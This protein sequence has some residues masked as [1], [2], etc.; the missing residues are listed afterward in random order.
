M[1]AHSRISF[2]V[3]LICLLLP[4]EN[5]IAAESNGSGAAQTIGLG[6]PTTAS[7]WIMLE[8]SAKIR[9]KAQITSKDHHQ[10]LANKFNH[11]TLSINL[12]VKP[13]DTIT[14]LV[15][16]NPSGSKGIERKA[17]SCECCRPIRAV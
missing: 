16:T 6:K 17:L 1:I 13:D 2:V 9:D 12:T 14:E 10:F 8:L 11:K 3:A 7:D 5:S 4:L 15:V